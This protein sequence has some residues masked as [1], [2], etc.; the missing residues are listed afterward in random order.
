MRLSTKGRLAIVALIDVAIH[1]EKGAVS[2]RGI[3]QRLDISQSYLELIFAR[4]RSCGIVGSV[5]GPGGGYRLR[6]PADELSVAEIVLAVDK[7]SAAMRTG[8]AA[9]RDKHGSHVGWVTEDLWMA[10]NRKLI[11]HLHTVS[12]RDLVD[13]AHLG[14]PERRTSNDLATSIQPGAVR[15]H[16]VGM[17]CGCV[18]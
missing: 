15:R 9:A 12:L 16:E 3:S 7:L 10:L 13:R 11:D 2:L 8:T 17:P 14:L 4:L 5:R 18:A 6:R 1:D